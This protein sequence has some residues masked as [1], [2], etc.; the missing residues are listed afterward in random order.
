MSIFLLGSQSVCNTS[1]IIFH[2][3]PSLPCLTQGCICYDA[4][5]QILQQK[6]SVEQEAK[7]KDPS[8]CRARQNIPYTPLPL[9]SRVTLLKFSSGPLMVTSATDGDPWINRR[10]KLGECH[11]ARMGSGASV[12]ILLTLTPFLHKIIVFPLL[13]VEKSKGMSLNN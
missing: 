13:Q 9:H 2:P 11:G 1:Y 5:P 4:S 10:E 3:V 6:V 12:L 8:N 7:S